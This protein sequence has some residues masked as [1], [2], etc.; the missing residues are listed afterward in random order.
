MF[1]DTVLVKYD[2]QAVCESTGNLWFKTFETLEE[3]SISI[4]LANPL[5]LK[6]SQSGSGCNILGT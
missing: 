6:L 4:V 3:R 1:A 2:S 5:R